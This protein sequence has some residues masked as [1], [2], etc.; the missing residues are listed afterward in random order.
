MIRKLA[1]L[2]SGFALAVTVGAC[3]EPGGNG[4]ATN[5]SGGGNQA[6]TTNLAA[7]VQQIGESTAETNTAHLTMIVE[8][9]GNKIE[10]E[11]DIEF[12]SDNVAMTLAMSLPGQGEV[13]AVLVD[14]LMYLDAGKELEPGKPWLKIDP[15]A[16]D[17]ISKSLGGMVEEMRKNADPRATV[18]TLKNAGSL[19]AEVEAELNG[20][21]TTHYT[22]LV[23][24][25]KVAAEQDDPE[26]ATTLDTLGVKEFPVELWTNED[27]L[28]VRLKM[29]PPMTDPNTGKPVEAVIQADYTKWGEPV[30]IDAPRADQVAE[31][32]G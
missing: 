19:T 6:V 13:S 21:R 12:R 27:G 18:E 1:V 9:G 8:A 14:G 20:E 24:F 29:E 11:G 31:L 7:L 10:T 30:E 28:P 25:E 5:G 23:D 22:I 32:P 26:L 15:A 3:G 4:A 16:D 2:L 17:T